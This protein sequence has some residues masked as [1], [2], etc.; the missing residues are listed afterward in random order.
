M[1]PDLGLADLERERQLLLRIVDTVSSGLPLGPLVVQVAALITDATATDVCFV[2]VLDDDGKR[3]TLA[4][5]TPPF[6]A[7]SGTVTLEIGEGISGWVAQHGEP[8]VLP[9]GKRDDPRYRYI[10]ALRGQDY[11]SM[12]SIPM[13][14]RLGRLVGVLN[15]HTSA[16]RTFGAEEVRLLTTIG[17]LV[18]GAIESAGLQHRLAGRQREHERFAARTVSLQEAE[19][20]RL[21]GE[22]HDG[23]SQ[24]IVSLSFHLSA[25]LSALP[26]DPVYAR[27]R[28]AD[29]R[30]LAIAA[31]DETRVAIAGL[32]PPVLDDLG[33]GPSIQSLGHAVL[34]VEVV[35]EVD[36]VGLPE[37]VETALYRIA[38]ESLQN[39]VKHAGATRVHVRLGPCAEGIELVVRDDGCGVDPTRAVGEEATYGM[40]GMRER[41]E[42]VGG[43]LDVG[44]GPEGGTQVRVVLSGQAASSAG[45]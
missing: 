10:P 44:P 14:G 26:E 36:P 4:G 43:H 28:I 9:D 35:V 33:L 42:L 7:L 38:Q 37:H 41:A 25:A 40:S 12:A 45:P 5:A 13:A 6:D 16:R 18:A 31:L 8:V 3:L 1:S 27:E 2:H 21:A 30:D 23:I 29:A 39:V 24:R 15:V 32:R 20:R 17:T 22:I 11:T 19:R 34:G